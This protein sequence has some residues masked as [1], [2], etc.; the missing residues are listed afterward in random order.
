MKVSL[1]LIDLFRSVDM[2][3][4]F[5]ADARDAGVDFRL[6]S[7]PCDLVGNFDDDMSSGLN[8]TPAASV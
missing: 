1:E 7:L 2:R 5:N 6:V 8:V 3:V 4:L